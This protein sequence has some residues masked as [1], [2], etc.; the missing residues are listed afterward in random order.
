MSSN[1][2]AFARLRQR[3]GVA[4]RKRRRRFGIGKDEPVIGLA[5]S[6][7]GIRSATF[8]LGFLQGLSAAGLLAK[9]DY[10]ST[11]S[12]GSYIGSFVGALFV[13]RKTRQAGESASVAPTFDPVRPLQSA[14]GREAVS[15]L[16]ESG[17]Y[18]MPSGTSDAFFGAAVVIRNWF[19]VQITIGLLALA[20]FWTLRLSDRQLGVVEAFLPAGISPL[21]AL[22]C[23]A[24]LGCAIAAAGAYWQTRRD[25]IPGPRWK[26]PVSNLLFWTIVAMGAWF[27]GSLGWPNF[28]PPGLSPHRA[29]AAVG[30][31]VVVLGLAMYLVAEARHGA[32]SHAS[33]ASAGQKER[34]LA[35]PQLLVAAEDRV[36]TVLSRWMAS[37]LQWFL[38]VG[39]L[40]AIDAAASRIPHALRTLVASTNWWAAAFSSWPVLVSIATPLLSW[41]AHLRL[42]RQ[43]AETRAAMEGA[44]PGSRLPALIVVVGCLL[45][46]F[47]LMLWSAVS[48][49]AVPAGGETTLAQF[50]LWLALI[51]ANAV[52]S[53]CYSFVNLSSLSTFYAARLRRAYIGAS[54]YGRGE[55]SVGL[56]DPQDFVGLDEYYTVGPAHG[57]P[58]H[59]I[60]LTIAETMTGASNL[61]ARDR[62]GKPMQVTPGGIAY[63]GD[64]PGRMIGAS[65]RF[66]EELP[67]ANWVAISG[68]AVAAA[69]GSGTS[70][71][72][73]ILTT[74]TNVRLGYWWK[75]E[76]ARKARGILWS[77]RSDTV[78]N[79]LFL[80]L[81]G[82]FAGTRRPR[83][84]LT[85]GGHFENT[86]IY[87]LLQREVRFIVA[88][89]NGADPDYEMADMV[90]LINRARTDLGAEI[91]F[92]GPKDLDP[93]LGKDSPVVGLIGPYASLAVRGSNQ[94]PGGPR[95]ALAKIAYHS[96]AVGHLLVVKPRL[97]FDEP[98]ELLAY[99]GQPGCSGFPQQ[100][101]GDQFFDEDQWEAYRRLGEL[102]A[103]QLFA[104]GSKGERGWLPAD[105]GAGLDG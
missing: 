5:L 37:A 22:I 71:G 62:K 95:A 58:A 63:E 65:R 69:I 13:P 98:P 60:N 30:A 46:A 85:D 79:Y 55:A 86:G 102:A 45:L 17:R 67:L 23:A 9:I 100:T 99:H 51:V 78:Q 90:R 27:G 97:T 76:R 104:S 77:S 84:Y 14:L 54:S 34:D 11:V 92:L 12:G 18:L 35:N 66:G 103:E 43:S 15:R 64:R 42:K 82:A 96:G 101:T 3:E 32:V 16:R 47:W 33:D 48:H 53:L 1:D 29:V 73:S 40:L 91:E 94:S 25:W 89:D 68:A 61:V 41:I 8:S 49:F 36:R 74:M 105:L 70:L 57:G 72:T 21:L 4:V 88:C 24:A 20:L 28:F 56:D 87:A 50:V 39:A 7:G 83:W 44:K 31:I 52:I 26:R 81:R 38:I 93:L 75:Q 80:E 6:G 10:L 19:A 59:I 2:E